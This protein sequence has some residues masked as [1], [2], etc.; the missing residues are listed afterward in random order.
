MHKESFILNRNTLQHVSTLLGHF[1][2]ELFVIVTLRLHFIVEWEC[3]VDCVLCC[4]RRRV[5]SVVPACSQNLKLLS[6]SNTVIPPVN[7]S[8]L[9]LAHWSRC[10]WSISPPSLVSVLCVPCTKHK[11]PAVTFLYLTWLNTQ[12]QLRPNCGL[13]IECNVLLFPFRSLNYV[14]LQ[15]KGNK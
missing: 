3:A 10:L 12:H 8:H 13:P 6:D 2:G 15:K 4:F 1:Q 9:L 7:A 11:T 5:F 14:S